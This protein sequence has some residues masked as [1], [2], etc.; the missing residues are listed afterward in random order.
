MRKVS[1][2]ASV[3]LLCWA[4]GASS[5]PDPM[6]PPGFPPDPPAAVA[7][8]D[9]D[10]WGWAGTPTV[11]SGTYAGL[12]AG[13]KVM[14]VIYVNGLISDDMPP[15]E[16]VL[17]NDGTWDVWFILPDSGEEAP[18]FPYQVGA[19]IPTT[20]ATDSLWFYVSSDP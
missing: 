20:N 5:W 13:Q 11:I 18:F 12:P 2:L 15:Q 6:P 10:P 3:C 16:A 4:P 7:I 8:T 17:H 19:W 1:L 9:P 14:V